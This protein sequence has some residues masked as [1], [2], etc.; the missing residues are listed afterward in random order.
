MDKKFIVV[1]VRDSVHYY[2]LKESEKETAGICG[3]VL[4][5][6][7]HQKSGVVDSGWECGICHSSNLQSDLTCGFCNSPK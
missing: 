1:R 2:R 3:C 5:Q 4:V 7:S 6:L